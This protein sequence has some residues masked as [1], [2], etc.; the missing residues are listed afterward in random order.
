[1]KRRRVLVIAVVAAMFL[2]TLFW[3][4]FWESSK[5]SASKGSI[6]PIDATSKA[7]SRIIIRSEAD[8]EKAKQIGEI[9]EDYGSFVLVA[10][11]TENQLVAQRKAQDLR[12]D[13]E[14]IESTVNFRSGGF[15]P[16]KAENPALLYAAEGGYQ[17]A[18]AT[19]DY[20]VVQFVGPI[21]DKW[22]EDLTAT[23]AEVIQYIAHNAYI[24]YAS[25]DQIEKI[26]SHPRVRWSGQYQPAFKVSPGLMWVFGEEVKP[27]PGDDTVAFGREAVSTYDVAVYSRANLESVRMQ[28]SSYGAETLATSV[29]PN[30]YFNVLRVK[31]SPNSVKSVLSIKDVV[32]VDPYIPPTREDEVATQIVAGNYTGTTGV[33]PGYNPLAQ[34]GVD[35]TNVTVGVVD[36]GIGIPGDGGCYITAT[37]AVNGPLR[38]ASSGANGH[39]HL[40]ATIVMGR[41]GFTGCTAVLDPNGFNYGIGVAP[42][43]H[44]INLPFLRSGYSGTDQ[45]CQEDAVVTAGPN[46]VRANITNNSWGAGTN[47]NAYDSLAAQYDGFVRDVTTAATIDPLC[48]IFS[49]GN[50]GTLGL[51]RPKMAKNVISVAASENVRPGLPSAGGS[52]GQADN[53]EQL[54]D[55]SSRGPGPG[56]GLVGRI[57][58]DITA[59]GDAITGGRSGGDALFGNI[60]AHHRISSGTSHAAP[61]VAGA[62]ALI[63]QAWKNANAGQNP[64]PAMIKA[65]IINSAVDVTGAGATPARPNGHEGWGRIHLK[66]ILNTGVPTIYINE[67][68]Q[69]LNTGDIH[70][71]TANVANPGQPVRVTLV[72]TDPPGVSDPPLVNNLDLEVTV[73]GNTYRGNVFSGGFS[74]TG[75]TADSIN[76]IENVFLPAGVSG[77]MA[78][79]I[80]ATN[81]PGDGILGNSDPTDQHFALVVFNAVPASLPVISPG[82]VSLT[83]EGCTPPNG[84]PDPNETVTVNL[85]ITNTGTAATSG[86]VIGTLQ[87]TGGVTSPSGPQNFGILSPGQ[88]STR[89]F[90]FTVANSVVCGSNITLTLNLSG[91]FTGSVT[92]TMTTGTLVTNTSTFSNTTTITIPSSGPATPYPSNISVSGVTGTVTKVTVELRLFNHTFPDDVD[93]LLVGPTGARVIIM[94]DVGGST[95]AVDLNITLDDSAPSSLPD[96]GP[97]TSGTFKPTNIGATDTFASPAPG[98]PYGS[99]LADFNGLNPNGTWSLYVVDDLGGDSGSFS[100]GWR[101]NITTSNPVC[102]PSC[103]P[104]GP[105]LDHLAVYV[106]DTGNNRIQR[107]TD[108]GATWHLV[109][110]GLGAT[111]GSFNKPQGV[112]SSENDQTIFVADTGNDRVQR[113]TDGGS[114]W[115]VLATF[116]AG[117]GSVSGPQ[118]VAYDEVN[119]ILYVADTGNHRIQKVT[120]AKTG[121]PVWEIF[122][123]TGFGAALGRMNSPRGIAVDKDGKVYVADTVNHRIQ[124]WDGS[125]WQLFQGTSFGAA[126]GKV[127]SPE[128][129]HVDKDGNVYVAD[130]GNNRIQRWNGSSWE[131]FNT[132]VASAPQGVTKNKN[133]Y[134]F[135]A[136]TG[137]NQIKRRKA[138]LSDSVTVVGPFGAAVGRFQ[139]PC[140]IR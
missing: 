104:T 127:S 28:I 19:G 54:P 133:G 3:S 67:T 37:N 72:W 56:P 121:S 52:T 80:R 73:G 90:T 140:G 77:P 38:G 68:V 102:A 114:T 138:D 85:T 66:N 139:G 103:T 88:S 87:A 98:A 107:T 8:R 116:G 34:F 13:M 16:L 9:V 39:G 18:A 32:A 61:Q 128:G 33:S 122:A 109:G 89:P 44:A 100:G 94:S 105:S 108:D 7:F 20:Y 26:K 125:S 29:L 134:V 31:M 111:A 71:V 62:A 23:G 115:Q 40:D 99:V 84:A 58:P 119:D 69:L 35:G 126:V 131:I 59:P 36:D 25:A 106:A 113:S 75:G 112:D 82:G 43:A 117:V 64:S 21:R 55:F 78:V 4:T 95:D 41:P 83:A 11:S 49:A 57:K 17:E 27:L 5:V 45:Q 130:T 92:Y 135:W 2:S 14:E 47:S 132:Q 136:E 91:G 97:L 81:L 65:Q 96:N 60:D 48:I 76:N 79:R 86:N 15:D 51:T 123:G 12:L 1:M 129:V 46:G 93:V 137:L 101:L 74:T 63:T 70:T 110:S 53:L 6:R 22:I 50:Q 42:Q 118:D 24:V 30:N 120:G 124:L 10:T